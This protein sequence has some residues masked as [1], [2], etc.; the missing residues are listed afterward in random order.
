MQEEKTCT[1]CKHY[2]GLA[3]PFSFEKAGYMQPVT[4][5]GFCSKD[6]RARGC[7]YPVYIPDSGSPC[8]AHVKKRGKI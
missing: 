4:V 6:T 7:F 5:Y 3:Q 8:K 2:A 1:T